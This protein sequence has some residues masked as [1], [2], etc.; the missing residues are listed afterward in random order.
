MN[1]L[2]KRLALGWEVVSL[3]PRCPELIPMLAKL[4]VVRVAII[5]GC[6]CTGNRFGDLRREV[7]RRKRLRLL[8]GGD[9]SPPV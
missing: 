7:R 4:V 1:A 3:I 9:P 2:R 5:V 8:I 6:W